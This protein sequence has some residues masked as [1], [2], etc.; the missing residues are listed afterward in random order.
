MMQEMKVPEGHDSSCQRDPRDG[1]EVRQLREDEVDRGED[2]DEVG[3]L[4]RLAVK[5]DG[6]VELLERC[7]T[8]DHVDDVH[9]NLDNQLLGNH[10]PE[11]ELFPKGMLPEL[12]VSVEPLSRDHLVHLDHLP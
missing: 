6:V 9:P 12:M 5:A 2:H 8:G 1:V 7:S 4:D 11:T 3:A 10:D